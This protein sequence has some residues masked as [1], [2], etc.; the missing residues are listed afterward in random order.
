MGIRVKYALHLYLVGKRMI[1]FL[2]L[3]IIEHLSSFTV[4][5]LRVEISLSR[6]FIKRVDHFEAMLFRRVAFT[7]NIRGP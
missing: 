4:E 7:A 6:S 5:K 3:M 1:D 2:V